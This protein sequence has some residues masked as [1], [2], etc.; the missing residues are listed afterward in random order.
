LT[1]SQCNGPAHLMETI[2]T[3]SALD[4]GRSNKYEFHFHSFIM[5]F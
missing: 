1:E 4:S 3:T 2:A 5:K